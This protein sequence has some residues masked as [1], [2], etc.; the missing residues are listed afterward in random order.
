[1]QR[2]SISVSV[3]DLSIRPAAPQVVATKRQTIFARLSPAERA[4]K[5]ASKSAQELIQAILGSQTQPKQAKKLRNDLSSPKLAARIISELKTA[6]LL[7][8]EQYQPARVLCLKDNECCPTTYDRLKM[9]ANAINNLAS[10]IPT[11]ASL[12]G[13]AVEVSGAADAL[14]S[15]SAQVTD[16]GLSA[17]IPLDRMSLFLYVP[18]IYYSAALTF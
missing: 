13:T 4:Q 11:P 2:T 8:P 12:V 5:K 16:H 1:M 6:A 15:L 14:A 3:S 17:P 9:G 7:Q 10:L 18:Q